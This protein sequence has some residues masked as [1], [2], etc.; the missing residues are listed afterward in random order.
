MK[1]FAAGLLTAL[2]ATAIATAQ[3]ADQATEYT[4]QSV[5]AQEATQQAAA[6]EAQN[7]EAMPIDEQPAPTLLL[8]I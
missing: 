3:P 5:P 7:N 2:C 6:P 1:K 4:Q 8:G